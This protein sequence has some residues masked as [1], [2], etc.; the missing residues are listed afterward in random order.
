MTFGSGIFADTTTTSSNLNSTTLQNQLA[1]S[2]VTV[3]TTSGLAGKGDITVSNP[4]SWSSGSDLKLAADR[5][6]NI[7]A[8]I[9]TT[10]TGNTNLT[11]EA[12]NSIFINSNAKLT[13][14][15]AGK[16]D[17]TLNADRDGIN[18]GAI[19]LKNGAA[20]DSNGGNIILGGSSNPL[21]ELKTRNSSESHWSQP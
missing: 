21:N 8:N 3:S 2:N 4:I 15:G 19:A 17:V 11:L 1:L 18:G 5:N 6:I 10:G 13:A 14:S 7:N 12:N 20:I 9:G 16:L